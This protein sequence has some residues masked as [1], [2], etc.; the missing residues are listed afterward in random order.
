MCVLYLCHHN[1]EVGIHIFITCWVPSLNMCKVCLNR[2]D[3]ARGILECTNVMFLRLEQTS[4]PALSYE[5]K[6]D[7]PETEANMSASII[8]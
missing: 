2:R 4:V 8:L 6:C 3:D 7:V 1:A 5:H